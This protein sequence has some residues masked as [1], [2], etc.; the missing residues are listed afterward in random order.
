V[1]W[2]ARAI[3]EINRDVLNN[4]ADEI[5]DGNTATED[6]FACVLPLIVVWKVAA[7]KSNMLRNPDIKDALTRV[8]AFLVRLCG[9]KERPQDIDT[10]ISLIEEFQNA[11]L[12]I[13]D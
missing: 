8:R 6:A 2:N 13:M 11:S 3:Q 10:I 4:I 12:M 1:Q 7:L 9:S 5:E